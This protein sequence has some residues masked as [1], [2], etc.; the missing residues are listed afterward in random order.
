MRCLRSTTGASTLSSPLT[1]SW[2][3]SNCLP[4]KSFCVIMLIMKAEWGTNTGALVRNSLVG[5]VFGRLTVQHEVPHQKPGAR[6]W[7][8]SC[9]CGKTKTVKSGNLKNGSTR[10]CGC[11][12]NDASR[13][14]PY[15]WLYNRFLRCAAKQSWQVD[16]SF[17]DFVEYTHIIACHYCEAPIVWAPFASNR[18]VHQSSAYNLD[19]KDTQAH[20]T[21]DNVVVC[22]WR[23][24]FS[25]ADRFTYEEWSKI[26]AVIRTFAQT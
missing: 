13:K 17:E 20:Y 12:L 4:N 23:C 3:C 19:R 16:L 24:N 22:C 6:L 26:G 15:E 2:C 11:W 25:K 8:C 7:L 14:R 1:E 9:L 21:K 10:S 18:S 5:K